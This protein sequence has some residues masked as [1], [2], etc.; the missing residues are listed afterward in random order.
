MHSTASRRTCRTGARFGLPVY[1]LG[2]RH[3]Q[4]CICSLHASSKEVP[5]KPA[6]LDYYLMETR[7]GDGSTLVPD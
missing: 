1:L 4:G 7:Y 5:E 2:V 3:I 6:I